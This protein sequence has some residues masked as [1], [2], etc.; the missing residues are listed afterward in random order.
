[1]IGLAILLSADA[2]RRHDRGT[3]RL[4]LLWPCR[5]P[6]PL[7]GAA[8]QPAHGRIITI[9][10]CATKRARADRFVVG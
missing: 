5:W 8:S 3:C 6:T 2:E 9:L 7:L 1:M 4:S 10:S